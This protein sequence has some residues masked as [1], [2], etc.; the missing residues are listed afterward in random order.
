MKHTHFF[1]SGVC[2]L[3]VVYDGTETLGCSSVLSSPDFLMDF[4]EDGVYF[5]PPPPTAYWLA[6]GLASEEQSVEGV[7]WRLSHQ[8]QVG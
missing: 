2:E 6:L 1:R 7:L 4:P 3:R 5:H 8:L